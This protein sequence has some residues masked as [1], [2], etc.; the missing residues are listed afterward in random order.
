MTSHHLNEVMFFQCVNKI[1]NENP[2]KFSQIRKKIKRAHFRK[3]FEDWPSILT[4][5]PFN[6]TE[7]PYS[8]VL[9]LAE[10]RNATIHKESALTSLEMARSALYTACVSSEAIASHMLGEKD[11]KYSKILQKYKLEPVKMFSK[12]VFP[13]NVNGSNHQINRTENTSAI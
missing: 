10:R 13:E 6:L 8:S 9:R 2:D 11:F 12:V 5:K 4:D 1:L 3:S 7:E